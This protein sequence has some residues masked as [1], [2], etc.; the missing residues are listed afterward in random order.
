MRGGSIRCSRPRLD[1]EIKGV[2]SIDAHSASLT[3]RKK[4]WYS[5][6]AAHVATSFQR[7][8]AFSFFSS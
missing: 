6:G 1:K 2:Q 7:F 5:R 8:Q 3:C 4:G